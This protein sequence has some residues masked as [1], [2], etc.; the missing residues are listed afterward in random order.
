MTHRKGRR[1]ERN[2]VQDQVS[3]PGVHHAARLAGAET[4]PVRAAMPATSG[5]ITIQVEPGALKAL[6]ALAAV[7]LLVGLWAAG[8]LP[9]L[10]TP[11]VQTDASLWLILMTGLTA[12]GLSCL[13]VQGGLLATTIAQREQIFIEEHVEDKVRTSQHAMP[14]LLFL[15]A[16]LVAYT[17]L[18]A[19]LGYFGSFISLSPAMRGAVQIVMGIVMLGVV[20]QMLD[21]HPMF[22][23]FALQPPKRA[24]RMIRN[25][26]KRGGVGAPLFLGALTV[27]IPCGV[28]Q[29]M[30]L[31]AVASGSPVRGAL[32][33][34]AFVLGT[35]PLFF[36]LGLLATRL[37]G[38]LHK[39]FLRLAAAAVA[40]MAISSILGGYHLLPRA[41]PVSGANALAAASPPLSAAPAAPAVGGVSGAP[42]AGAAQEAVV[43]VQG[44]GYEP[45]VVQVKAGVPTRLNL[46]T[47]NTYGC[48]RAFVIP[49]LGLQK[50]LPVTGTE[51]VDLP[52]S[53]P[54][55]IPFTCSMGM[56]NGVIEVVQ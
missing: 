15:G 45:S 40:V 48:T 16:K 52:A 1:R 43:N 21:V 9:S 5:D 28:T 49:S 8:A 50:I 25:Q 22:R 44:Y 11:E 12:G 41:T 7:G 33:L 37:S 26:A 31:L 29:A 47:N 38:A 18:G 53:A 23:Y 54:G 56:Y 30:E 34:F 32:I 27:L 10:A 2:I 14:I 17:I 36:I 46:V 19:L 35:T 13:A 39:T 6:A 24:Q 3:T 42:A 51:V 20:L 4:M 55:Q